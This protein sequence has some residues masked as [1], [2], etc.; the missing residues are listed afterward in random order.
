MTIQDLPTAFRANAQGIEYAGVHITV[1]MWDATLL[2]DATLV[3]RTLRRAATACGATV[4]D[5]FLHRF[6]PQGLTAVAL[7]AE[8]H[9]SMH[10]WP[11]RGYAAWDI[12][13]CGSCDPYLAI[14]VLNETFSPGRLQIAEQ[15]RGVSCPVIDVQ[16]AL[17]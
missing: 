14:P 4:L 5:V 8:S 11:E 9:I 16:G 12:F 1:D 2:N 10:A 6:E 7:L 17:S 13:T 15:K 3:S